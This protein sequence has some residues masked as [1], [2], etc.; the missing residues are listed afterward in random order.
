M[1][2]RPCR[3]EVSVRGF[4]IAH[5]KSDLM[6]WNHHSR[7]PAFGHQVRLWNILKYFCMQKKL[8]INDNVLFI[9]NNW[10]LDWNLLPWPS[11]WRTLPLLSPMRDGRF[12]FYNTLY[13]SSLN[14]YWQ[15]QLAGHPHLMAQ[16]IQSM[17]NMPSS[18]SSHST[19][20][21]PKKRRKELRG[22]KEALLSAMRSSDEEEIWLGFVQTISLLN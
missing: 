7:R 22:F 16:I 10:Q 9:I 6:S 5:L 8:P 11:L 4:P 15:V 18:S 20:P 2:V 13:K 14:P 1:K 17:A 12:H 19:S 3:L 21:A